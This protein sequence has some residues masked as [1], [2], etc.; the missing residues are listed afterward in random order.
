M[1][2]LQVIMFGVFIGVVFTCG[3][4]LFTKD[5]KD[6][7][8]DCRATCFDMATNSSFSPKDEKDRM[9]MS[10][11][12]VVRCWHYA[13]LSCEAFPEQYGNFCN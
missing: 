7:I 13:N 10:S 8:A 9:R 6:I 12:C 5:H 3:L 4:V 1:K 11:Q 2:K